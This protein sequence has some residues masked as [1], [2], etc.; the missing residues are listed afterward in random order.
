MAKT[1]WY[2][3]RLRDPYFKEAKKKGYRARS[4]YKLKQVQ[5]RFHVIRRGDCVVDLGAA[6]GGWSQ[7]AVEFV[8]D[9]GTVLGVDL[10]RVVP[11]PGATFLQGDFTR[12]ETH[13]R[14]AEALQA[15]GKEDVDVVLSDMAPDM[16][17]NYTLDQAR[18]AHL[19]Q[20]ALRFVDARLRPGG[21]FV[22]KVF[23]GEDFQD[24]REEVRAR[25]KRV[26]QFHPPAS[27]KASSEVYLVG[28]G[29]KGK[30]PAQNPKADSEE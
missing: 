24:L 23:E 18:S 30:A 20:M 27:R 16:S 9:E 17:G 25:F 19:V 10:R 11:V 28:K 14:L 3:E 21:H 15:A 7:V 4:A 26:M 8:G 6:P 13:L 12:K 22:A 1:R 5:K 29:H 2:N